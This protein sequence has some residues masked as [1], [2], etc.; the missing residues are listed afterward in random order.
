MESLG[1]TIYQKHGIRWS[2]LLRLPYWDPTI[3]QVV[4]A[5]HN[6][7]L[8]KLQHHCHQILHMNADADEEHG[9]IPLHSPEEQQQYLNTGIA[10][11]RKGSRTELSRIRKGYVI[12]L[13]LVNNVNP[14][15]DRDVDLD[16]LQHDGDQSSTK[17]MYI[18]ALLQWVSVVYLLMLLLSTSM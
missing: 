10:A 2:E 17:S 14:L 12:S 5:M 3:F 13:A 9:G 1:N 15:G 16:P 11:I 6:L 4:E 18:E 7:F 8:G